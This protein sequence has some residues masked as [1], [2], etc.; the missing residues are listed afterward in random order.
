MKDEI[1]IKSP[2]TER[3]ERTPPGQHVT[4]N[5]LVLH[6]GSTYTVDT[7]RWRFRIFGLVEKERTLSY[8][9]FMNL[10]RVKVFSDIHCV[11]SWSKLNNAWGG[12]HGR[13]KE[14]R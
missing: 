8:G 10:P 2:D 13:D 14:Y 7:S 11:T 12:K 5:F 3:T 9:E 6:A 1:L 4:N